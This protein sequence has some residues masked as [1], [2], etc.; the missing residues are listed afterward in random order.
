MRK[1]VAALAISLALIGGLGAPL[2]Y[3]LN[4]TTTTHS[5]AIPTAGPQ[6]GGGFGGF[7][8][9][10][11][12][13]GFGG[14][15][16]VGARAGG[17]GRPTGAGST[18]GGSTGTGST[19]GSGPTSASAPAGSS[20]RV[21]GGGQGAGPGGF[22][23]AGGNRSNVI[24]PGFGRGGGGGGGGAGGLL[25]GSTPSKAL[26]TE[27]ESGTKRY[28]WIAAT[29]GANE[30]AGYQLGTGQ[31]VMAIGGFNGTDPAPTLAQFESWVKDGD[32]HWYIASGDG[33]GGGLPGGAG[34]STSSVADQIT[35]WVES[36]YKSTTVGGTTIYNL[37]TPTSSS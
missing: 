12:G 25:N 16:G 15:G 22:G 21:A 36:H 7:G 24:R 19:F 27:L 1:F 17:F 14:R 23:A 3:A 30:A 33:F 28:K 34:N 4:T 26:V 6:G 10:R 13:G 9:G 35:S 8:G 37:T 5:G 20:S 29:V 32:I 18:F 2:A 11:P 31:A